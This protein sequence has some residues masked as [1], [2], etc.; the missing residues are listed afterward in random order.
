MKIN[1][2]AIKKV[3]IILI[4]L[5][6]LAIA[7]VIG[8]KY[9]KSAK[10][11][12]KL[13]VLRQ[14]EKFYYTSND[15]IYEEDNGN[16]FLAKSTETGAIDLWSYDENYE[17]LTQSKLELGKEK[18]YPTFVSKEEDGYFM[19]FTNESSTE[20]PIMYAAK[21]NNALKE[22][23][24]LSIT[25]ESPA[26]ELMECIVSEDGTRIFYMAQVNGAKAKNNLITISKEGKLLLNKP[27]ENVATGS[28]VDLYEKN[29]E[30][31]IVVRS[32]V[33]VVDERHVKI[34][35]YGMNI[36]DKISKYSKST[37]KTNKLKVGTDT[38]EYGSKDKK[39]YIAKINESNETVWEKTF[40]LKQ[41]DRIG[42]IYNINKLA[43]G[44]LAVAYVEYK[45]RTDFRKERMNDLY[46]LNDMLILNEKGEELKRVDLIKLAAA[47]YAPLKYDVDSNNNI[48][49]YAS[50]SQY[51]SVIL[52][53]DSNLNLTKKIDLAE[54]T[55]PRFVTI[56][57][58]G[59]IY[60][61][62]LNAE[63]TMFILRKA[64]EEEGT[65]KEEDNLNIYAEETPAPVE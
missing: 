23:W 35:T 31:G 61:S 40:D 52:K 51:K 29:E 8:I 11:E 39:G 15:F 38:L 21:V 62:D 10:A 22:V 44:N 20:K 43:N 47:R 9:L 13:K 25:L 36:S 45:E 2:K 41:E 30:I 1:K 12:E 6:A 24:K 53:L 56:S 5:I 27:L 59:E 60:Y 16:I 7:A 26:E 4:V 63:K 64:K 58:L 17:L 3:I 55:K 54:T 50:I 46:N 37:D 14:H 48:Y 18:R 34:T 49:A 65:L 33:G 42:E 28:L 19:L 32:N 57:S